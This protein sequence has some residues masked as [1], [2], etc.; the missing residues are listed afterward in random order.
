MTALYGP[1][2]RVRDTWH[3]WVTV[4]EVLDRPEAVSVPKTQYRVDVGH[5]WTTVIWPK[6]ICEKAKS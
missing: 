6:D 4:V 1:G 2:D 5:G 3:G